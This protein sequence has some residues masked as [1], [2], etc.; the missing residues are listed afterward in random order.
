MQCMTV[1]IFSVRN[2]KN[3]SGKID[4]LQIGP[5]FLVEMWKAS[6][7]SWTSRRLAATPKPLVAIGDCNVSALAPKKTGQIKKTLFRPL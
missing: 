2:I 5:F 4:F 6:S 1:K 3:K 7:D